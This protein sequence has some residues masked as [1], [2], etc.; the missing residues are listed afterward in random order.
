MA[1]NKHNEEPHD[2]WLILVDDEDRIL[3]HERRS[4]CHDGTGLLH[5]AF[6]IYLKDRDGCLLLQQR[7]REKRLWPEFWSNSCCGHP[8]R[9]ETIEAAATRRLQEELGLSVPLSFAFKYSYEAEFGALGAERELCSVFLGS[10][11][12]ETVR[13]D[14]TEV[15]DWKRVDPEVL[16]KDLERLK[17]FTPWF[18]IAWETLA[19]SW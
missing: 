16:E 15:M 9:G 1:A 11:I 5:R 8:E 3:G 19:G 4:L 13:P 6:S 18:R 7:S 17:N 14:P 2:P 12:S 10:L